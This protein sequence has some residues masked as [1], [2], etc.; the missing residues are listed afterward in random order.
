MRV[1]LD[2][3]KERPGIKFA[4]ADLLGIPHRITIGDRNLKNGQVEYR[5]RTDAD[6]ELLTQAAVLEKLQA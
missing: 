1:L 2:D 4:D 6:S 5:R 3:R